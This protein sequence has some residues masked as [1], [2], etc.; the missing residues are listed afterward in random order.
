MLGLVPSRIH[1]ALEPN[2]W[3][4]RLRDEV[5]R[6]LLNVL[7]LFQVFRPRVLLVRGEPGHVPPVS[8]LLGILLPEFQKQGS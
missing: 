3:F 7:Q 8:D 1:S 6:L 5:H 2:L 4:D